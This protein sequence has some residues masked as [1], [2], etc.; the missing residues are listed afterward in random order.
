MTRIGLV[1]RALI[2]AI[3]LAPA[4]VWGG[5]VVHRLTQGETLE[6]VAQR[7]WGERDWAVLLRTHNR[8]PAGPVAA[9]LKLRVPVPSDHVV[10][11]GDTWPSLAEAMIDDPALGPLLAELN[12]LDPDKPLQ[13]GRE[14]HAPAIATYRLG[15]GESLAAVARRFLSGTG[16]WK[17]LA[18]VNHLGNPHSLRAGTELRVPLRPKAPQ[19][20]ADRRPTAPVAAAKPNPRPRPRPRPRPDMATPL[21]TEPIPLQEP[22]R[23]A[24]N[25]YLDGRYEEALEQ[26]EN[27]RTE[28]EVSG[29]HK[30]QV[31]VLE[32]LTLA[33]VAFD[34]ETEA[35]E[36]YAAL[37][38]A[39]P[40]HRW[41]LDRI[42]PKVIRMTSLCQAR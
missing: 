26:L 15:R 12:D 33:H 16:D 8:L 28:T 39:E 14:I 35:C 10:R 21:E 27:L 1:R 4:G 36:A 31:T 7:Y 9:G 2:L 32:Y 30:D 25:A 38:T 24:V 29:S 41:D 5:E 23:E 6:D 37:R 19:E 34:D 3:L 20:P 42:S 13:P 22:I 17:L 11:P 18:R 40:E